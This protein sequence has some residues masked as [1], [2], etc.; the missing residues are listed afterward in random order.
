MST[1]N[2]NEETK[3][4]IL[5]HIE[6]WTDLIGNLLWHSFTGLRFLELGRPQSGLQEK[7]FI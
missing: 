6:K 5:G 2:T 4:K 1:Q 3:T 7:P